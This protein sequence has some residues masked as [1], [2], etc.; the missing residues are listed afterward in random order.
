MI[1]VNGRWKIRNPKT[2]HLVLTTSKLGKEIIR[3]SAPPIPN[4]CLEIIAQMAPLDV[5]KVSKFFKDIVTEQ[6]AKAKLY[7]KYLNRY[8]CSALNYYYVHRKITFTG[9]DG[10][11]LSIEFKD[12]TDNKR[13]FTIASSYDDKIYTFQKKIWCMVKIFR[14]RKNIPIDFARKINHILHNVKECTTV[15]Y[16]KVKQ[17]DCYMLWQ[18]L[19][20]PVQF[21]IS[22]I[23][24][25][26]INQID[27]QPWKEINDK[28]KQL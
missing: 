12:T 16:L 17:Y 26:P 13:T 21:D 11:Q 2:N 6:I 28:Y 14:L 22:T 19:G 8:M 10:H 18:E 15:T 23:Y 9:Y 5:Y 1:L 27:E 20:R 25:L 7:G 3:E 4:D 24:N